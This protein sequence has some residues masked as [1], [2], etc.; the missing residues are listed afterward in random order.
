M[1]NRNYCTLFNSNYL[2]RGMAL[3]ESLCNVHDEFCLYI[4]AFDSR[5]KEYLLSMQLDKAVII[6]LEE[7][8]DEELLAIKPSRTDVEYCWTCTPSTIKYAIEKYNLVDCT[9]LDADLYFYSSPEPIFNELS[10]YTVGLT[11]HNYSP[12]YDL[13]KASGKY[14]VQFVFF[15]NSVLGR[16]PLDW[17]RKECINWC[18]SYSEGGKFGD[19]KY[20]DHFQIKFNGV[21][22]IQNPGAG[23]APWNILKFS[24]ISKNKKILIRTKEIEEFLIFYHFH[25]LKVDFKNKTIWL[26]KWFD[27]KT[28]VFEI[29]YKPYIERLLYYENSIEKTD[30]HIGEFKIIKSNRIELMFF[31]TVQRFF[32]QSNFFRVAFNKLNYIVNKII[33]LGRS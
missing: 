8:E 31:Y 20:L 22:D 1:E 13:S 25:K 23:V 21:H 6:S 11:P 29:V 9:Y 15:R 10:P 32:G 4:F 16:V 33:I 28:D 3:Y 14:C 19:Q 30:Y 17:W 26:G 5:T 18:F 2:S 7:F 24:F 27:F 12:E